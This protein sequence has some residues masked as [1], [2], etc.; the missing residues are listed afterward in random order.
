MMDGADHPESAPRLACD[1]MCGGLARWLRAIGYDT[2][3]TPGIDDAEL[4]AH[5]RREGRII[6]SSDGRLFERRVI[7]TGQVRALRLPRGLKLMEQVRYVVCALRLQV[8]FPRCTL[9]NGE[10]G[11]VAREEVANVV[12]ARSLIWAREFYRCCRCGHV[13]WEG[14]HWRRIEQVRRDL[15]RLAENPFSEPTGAP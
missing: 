8:G 10:L 14:T 2:T 7:T 15:T 6:I 13:F 3:Y 12:P 1:A 11:P 9:C 5:A 4:I